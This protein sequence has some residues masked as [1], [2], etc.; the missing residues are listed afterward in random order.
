[1][2]TPDYFG[3]RVDRADIANRIPSQWLDAVRLRAL[4]QGLLDLVER[5]LLLPMRQI[6]A[7]QNPGNAEGVWLERLALNCP[8]P[9]ISTTSSGFFNFGTPFGRPGV[10][11]TEYQMRDD[12]YQGLLSMCARMLYGDGTLASLQW[13]A[14]GMFPR[15][16]YSD[17]PRGVL[18]S[19]RSDPNQLDIV[20]AIQD[21]L[22]KAAGRAITVRP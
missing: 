3:G 5:E 6:E 22:P 7:Y 21:L 19:L 17:G 2:T 13:Q 20:R 14:R 15:V 16:G 12:D 10:G 18:V 9:F 4:I 11:Q 8:R 1:M